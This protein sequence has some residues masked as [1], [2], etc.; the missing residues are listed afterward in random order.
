MKATKHTFNINIEVLDKEV[1]KSLLYDVMR[2]IDHD[3]YDGLL[4]YY[5]GDFISWDIDSQQ[6]KF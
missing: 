4:H 2:Q 6:V 3:V 1:I 5:D